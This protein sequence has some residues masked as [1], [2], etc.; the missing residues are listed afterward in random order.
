M[1]FQVARLRKAL[2]ADEAR[3]RLNS[4]VRAQVQPEVVGLGEL[5]VAVGAGK[6][7]VA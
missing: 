5:A 1:L 6:R 3:V 7:A 2:L 4:G